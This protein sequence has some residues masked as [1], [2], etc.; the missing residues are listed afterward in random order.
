MSREVRLFVNGTPYSVNV[1]ERSRSAVRFAIAGRE[2]TVEFASEVASSERVDSRAPSAPQPRAADV[3]ACQPA[4]SD[5]GGLTIR[6]P[7]PGVVVDLLVAS[8]DTVTAGQ[9]LL[10]LEAMK[11][12][13]AI[14]APHAGTVTAIHVAAGRE[15]ADSEPLLEF[16]PACTSHTF[17]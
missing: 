12:H 14:V 9:V 5:A 6:A 2:Y 1:L 17:S 10:H 7:L 3:M 4:P 11:M 13:N 8:G 15:V 16:E